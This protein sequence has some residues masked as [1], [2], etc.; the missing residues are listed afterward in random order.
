MADLDW[1]GAFETGAVC[2]VRTGHCSDLFARLDAF[3][4]ASSGMCDVEPSESPGCADG[5]VTLIRFPTACGPM[6]G[7][8]ATDEPLDSAVA[9]TG[10]GAT[11]SRLGFLAG[12][13]RR[14]RGTSSFSAFIWRSRALGAGRDTGRATG[15]LF[16]GRFS[17]GDGESAISYA[18]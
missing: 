15:S 13:L 3:G 9:V 6:T 7:E 11:R 2:E 18:V 8:W 5:D 14:P 16:G 10:G 17:D 1:S 12:A 4:S